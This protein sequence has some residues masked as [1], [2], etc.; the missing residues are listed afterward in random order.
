MNHRFIVLL[1]LIIQ[2]GHCTPKV[3][4][5][6]KTRLNEFR[7][8]RMARQGKGIISVLLIRESLI[9]QPK[10]INLAIRSKTSSEYVV[11]IPFA[12]SDLIPR[13]TQTGRLHVPAS[14]YYKEVEIDQGVY[15]F[16]VAEEIFDVFHDIPVFLGKVT[17]LNAHYVVDEDGVLLI[18]E[19]KF[20]REKKQKYLRALKPYFYH[21]EN[22]THKKS[23][24]HRVL[25]QVD[26]RGPYSNDTINKIELQK[27]SLIAD[28]K[29]PVEYL[30]DE[31]Y[32]MG[33]FK[34]LEHGMI[35]DPRG[36]RHHSYYN[37]VFDLPSFGEVYQKCYY[38][39]MYGNFVSK[40]GS[41]IERK[42]FGSKHFI[43]Q[44]VCL[45]NGDYSTFQK[46][47]IRFDFDMSKF[48][49]KVIDHQTSIPVRRNY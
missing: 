16:R 33:E 19:S 39:K 42:D 34:D 47:D 43:K 46:M 36:S 4:T 5:G 2:Y 29:T 6:A 20:F 49:L 21:V 7:L 12:D 28:L 22:P 40:R 44:Q 32:L 48:K 37:F 17:P 8:K 23:F 38:F 18:K 15:S 1:L 27:V 24:P 9:D 10:S 14:V 45:K 3:L 30:E 11:Q 41:T 13:E 25:M 35:E 26:F 31:D